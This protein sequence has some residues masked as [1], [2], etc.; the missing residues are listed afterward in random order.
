MTIRGDLVELTDDSNVSDT[1]T[2]D[3]DNIENISWKFNGDDPIPIEIFS[4][5][6]VDSGNITINDVKHDVFE[7]IKK[8]EFSHV[9]SRIHVYEEMFILFFEFAKENSSK[10]FEFFHFGLVPTSDFFTTLSA[11]P[12]IT[13]RSK[14]FLFTPEA[15]SRIEKHLAEFQSKYPDSSF[16]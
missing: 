6:S 2:E 7:E 5:Y 4:L 15:I 8:S 16:F 13:I 9:S 11:N 14:K 1:K 12:V 3:I 10:D